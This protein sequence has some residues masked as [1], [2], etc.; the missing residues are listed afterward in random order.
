MI[1]FTPFNPEEEQGRFVNYWSDPLCNIA[2]DP[3]K[4]REVSEKVNSVTQQMKDKGYVVRVTMQ[5]RVD[6]HT[7]CNQRKDLFYFDVLGEKS[8]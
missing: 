1:L 3:E 7:P 6:E 4:F 5:N 8:E 2:S